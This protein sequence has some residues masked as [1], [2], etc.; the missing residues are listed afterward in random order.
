VQPASPAL[1]QLLTENVVTGCTALMNRAMVE[2][3]LPLPEAAQM[4]DHWAALI[5]RSAG[6]M[7]GVAEATMLYRQHESNVVGATKQRSFSAKVDRL[8]GTEGVHARAAQ[9]RMDRAQAS[10]LLD[11]CGAN[12][13]RDQRHA[14][15]A[16]VVLET[17][18]RRERLT[19]L[20]RWQLW[21]PGLERRIA[22]LLD[23]IRTAAG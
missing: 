12:M 1:T 8:L 5:A 11:R 16:F 18:S 4:H 2:A 6:A 17:M 10:A 22:Q 14:I 20:N 19:A 3:M 9:Y 23:L 15:Q 21:R 7:H 13:T